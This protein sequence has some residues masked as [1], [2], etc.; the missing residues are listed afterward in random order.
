MRRKVAMA[1]TKYSNAD[2]VDL[3]RD[4]HWSPVFV[5]DLDTLFN[6][7]NQRKADIGPY[8]ASQVES[9]YPRIK[10]KI[11]PADAGLYWIGFYFDGNNSRYILS[12]SKRADDFTLAWS[13]WQSEEA[14]QE[15]EIDGAACLK[16][17][18]VLALGG[19]KDVDLQFSEQQNK[20]FMWKASSVHPM[21]V[22]ENAY[23]RMV[24][25]AGREPGVDPLTAQ[26]EKLAQ[27]FMQDEGQPVF[28]DSKPPDAPDEAQLAAVRM[29]HLIETFY[30]F[31]LLVRYQVESRIDIP[32][33]VRVDL[34]GSLTKLLHNGDRTKMG[35]LSV[36]LTGKIRELG[37][38]IDALNKPER[39]VLFFLKG[40]RALNYFLGTPEKGENDWD[41]QVVIDPRL[42]VEKWY[43]CF[44]EV[45]DVL[46]AALQTFRSEFTQLVEAN[47]P[48]FAEYL[49]DKT[50]PETGEDEEIDENEASDV[51]SRGAR[52][53]C[54][55][56]LIDIGIPRRDSAS[57]L[58]EWT[59]LSADGAL[60]T[61]ADGVVYPHREYYLNEYLMMIRDAFLPNADVKKAPKRITRFGMVLASDNP[62]GQS[63]VEARRLKALPKTMAKIEGFGNKAR[64]ELFSMMMSQFVEA[65]NLLQDSELAALFDDQALATITKPPA[66]PAELA[67]LLGDQQKETAG[68]VGVAHA[69]SKLM[70]E[71]WKSRSDFF[72]R[73]REFFVPF[74][75][76]LSQ[77]GRP[78]LEKIDAQF[79]IAGSYAALLHADHLAAAPDGLEPI[80]RILVK[81]QCPQ[82]R[83]EAE[84]M[85]AVRETFTKA[86]TV[87][88][89]L[90]L[91]DVPDPKNRSL[92]LY[93]REK[94][95]IGNFTYAPL[96]MK[97]RGAAQTGA[98]LPVLASI[99][100]LPVLD[101]RYLVAD[102]RKKTSKIDEQGSR[103]T[104]ASATAA[105]SELVSRFDFESDDVSESD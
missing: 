80:R 100:G 20:A 37:E 7:M 82:G 13:V 58:E 40:G 103:R 81:L 10:E 70:G 56:E 57:G 6:G 38:K 59:R 96:V 43:E 92:V 14:R 94:V 68:D 61:A 32:E 98:Q 19:R 55:A 102:Y 89:K 11:G 28:L 62:E 17:L 88:G 36:W 101:L 49:K 15:H 18:A 16:K 12:L 52:A 51:S 65:Y 86:A 50:G 29:N 78:A 69:L 72:A 48:Q 104:L 90:R 3:V 76:D 24:R 22:L 34:S 54:K 25:K 45:H 42:K 95:T 87:A 67:K 26:S 33:D 66:L 91:G 39:R 44:S 9:I 5:G 105:A 8:V 27:F 4:E 35:W 85:N 79:A 77:L 93:W 53:S 63:P 23:Q 73:Q 60:K 41:T 71:H 21:Q 31:R 64:R 1:P 97:I 75:R 74:L 84:T 47:V 99:D 46:L 30:L 2:F 83:N